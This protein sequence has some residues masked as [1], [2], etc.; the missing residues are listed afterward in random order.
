MMPRAFQVECEFVGHGVRRGQGFAQIGEQAFVIEAFHD[1]EYLARFWFVLGLIQLR[2]QVVIKHALGGF[3]LL[4]GFGFCGRRGRHSPPLWRGSL[5]PL[6]GVAVVGRVQVVFLKE[7]VL[8]FGTALP[9]SG[10]KLP[11][12]RGWVSQS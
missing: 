9:P 4:L 11:R 7:G 2:Q 5:L 8:G 3:V 6:G 12:H 1:G 10:S